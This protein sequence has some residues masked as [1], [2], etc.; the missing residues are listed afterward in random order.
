M[1]AEAEQQP[2]RGPAAARGRSTP[3][4]SSTRWPTRSS[5]GCDEL[6]DAVP[7]HERA[8]AEMLV[9]DARQA[10]KEQAPMD[11]VR[12]LTPSCSS[13]LGRAAGHPGRRPARR[14]PEDPPGRGRGRGRDRRRVRPELSTSRS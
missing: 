7:A 3:A 5:A 9:A 14:A 10:V 11:R 8:R 6:G 1:V 12:A 2:G 13:V 4:T